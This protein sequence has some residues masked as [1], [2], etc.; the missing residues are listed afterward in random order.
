M[1][2]PL[3]GWYCWIFSPVGFTH[4]Y[5]DYALSGHF[6][7]LKHY[8]NPLIRICNLLRSTIGHNIVYFDFSI[9]MRYFFQSNDLWFVS[10]HQKSVAKLNNIIG[11]GVNLQFTLR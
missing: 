4:G 7:V 9:M 8:F 10:E 11:F 5:S 6:F 1:F 2:S 3:R